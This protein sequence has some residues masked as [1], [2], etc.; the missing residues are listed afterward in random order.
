MPYH[1]PIDITERDL[2]A[3]DQ[4]VKRCNQIYAIDRWGEGYFGI[5]PA[6]HLYA[7][8]DPKG[9]T[10]VD[11]ALLAEQLDAEGLS[12]PVL[13]RFNDILR[14]RVESLHQAFVDASAASGY[15]GSLPTRLSDQG[16]P[17]GR[18]GARDPALRSCR[19][20]GRQQARADGGAGTLAARRSGG[21]QRLQGPR[22]Y[23]ARP[24]R[25]TAW[26]C[27]CRS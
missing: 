25:E 15:S 12:L 26:V 22:V 20:G 2:L 4:G 3:M 21:L 27:G 6:G 17:A 10:E 5:N 23:P 11:L 16:Q 24:D 18:R 7:R 1:P 14:H 8:P 9:A 13:V 19:S